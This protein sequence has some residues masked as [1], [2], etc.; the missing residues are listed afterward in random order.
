MVTPSREAMG[1]SPSNVFVNARTIGPH[2]RFQLFEEGSLVHLQWLSRDGIA[3][4]VGKTIIP[5]NIQDH[6]GAPV[7]PVRI[8]IIKV[9]T[10]TF[11]DQ[12]IG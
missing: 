4:T 7:T 5:G 11:D 6:V 3:F 9:E 1:N 12:V 2:G 8:F 10:D